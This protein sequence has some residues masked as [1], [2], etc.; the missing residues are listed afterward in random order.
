MRIAIRSGDAV[1]VFLEP[2]TVIFRNVNDVKV[3]LTECLRAVES[4]ETVIIC[5]PNVPV[6]EIRA[7]SAKSSTGQR[8]IG[9]AQDRGEPLPGG[10]FESLPTG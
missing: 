5:R 9:L 2:F 8:P 7:L 1:P 10:F 6:A 3:H 4:G